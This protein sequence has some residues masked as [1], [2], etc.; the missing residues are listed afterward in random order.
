MIANE[1]INDNVKYLSLLIMRQCSG[2]GL[3]EVHQNQY[4]TN[5]G[6]LP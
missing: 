4:K 6:A 2:F 3:I 5:V 1:N